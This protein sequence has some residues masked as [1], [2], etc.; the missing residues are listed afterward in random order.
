MCPIL[1]PNVYFHIN[2]DTR[3]GCV[4]VVICFFLSVSSF[5]NGHDHIWLG[6]ICASTI[7]KTFKTNDTRS[8]ETQSYASD[9]ERLRNERETG[10][11]NPKR[12]KKHIL[13]MEIT[14]A[15]SFFRTAQHA[16]LSISFEKKKFRRWWLA[17]HC[18]FIQKKR[19]YTSE[20][21][22]CSLIIDI[23]ILCLSRTPKCIQHLHDS[24]LRV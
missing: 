3:S 17:F 13:W 15:L 9:A 20:S 4:C 6:E 1:L 8:L 7:N 5:D 12:K 23:W 21:N 14:I 22:F 2:A 18:R 24:Y 11:L 19:A 10:R 16:P